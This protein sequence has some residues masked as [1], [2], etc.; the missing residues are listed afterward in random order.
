MHTGKSKGIAVTVAAVILSL[1]LCSC[2]AAAPAPET[3]SGPDARPEKVIALS[4][5]NADLWILAG[6][7][8]AATS[9]DAM[10]IEG[11]N[12]DAVS[13]GDMDHVSLEAVKALDPD[14][15]ILF[16]TDPAQKALGEAAEA[17][18]IP[19]TYTNID[20]FADYEE[21][22]KT[23]TSMT[24][25]KDLYETYVEDVRKEIDDIIKEVPSDNGGGTYLMLHV[26]ATKSKAEKN[27]YFASEI[28]NDLGLSNI[29]ADNSALDEL[30]IEAVVTADPDYVFVIPRGDEKK[31][32]ASFDELFTSEPAWASLS[33]VK[34]GRYYLL[35]KDMFGL[36]P[37]AKWA[38]AYRQAFDL[39]YGK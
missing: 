7:E 33:A 23:F 12:S 11:L 14:M 38:E 32:M 13:L 39:I 27:D 31:A 9:D 16:S 26:S 34:N 28:F 3:G 6:G 35:P 36:K 30:S 4:K 29:A 20:N 5:S 19:V 15:L 37:N 22:M 24:G 21:I 1:L 25:R 2:T 18:G 17:V 8:L 10:D